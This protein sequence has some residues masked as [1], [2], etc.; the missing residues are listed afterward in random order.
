[1]NNILIRRGLVALAGAAMLASPAA[2]ARR[3]YVLDKDGT[4]ND[5]Q[6][7]TATWRTPWVL[8][9]IDQVRNLLQIGERKLPETV[10]VSYREYRRLAPRLGRGPGQVGPPGTVTLDYDPVDPNRELTFEPGRYAVDPDTTFRHYREPTGRGRSSLV[11]DLKAAILRTKLMHEAGEPGDWRG[12]AFP[13]LRQ[14]L[15]F[16]PSSNEL[17]LV[18]ARNHSPGEWRRFFGVLKEEGLVNF[19]P[20]ALRVYSMTDEESLQFGRDGMGPKKSAVMDAVA[21]DLLSDQDLHEELS[22]DAYEAARGE[23]RMGHTLIFGE[24]EPRYVD[25]LRRQMQASSSDL[26]LTHRI[27]FVLFNA[28]FDEEVAEAFFPWRYTVIH[29]GVGRAA[30]PA[31]IALW[32]GADGCQPLL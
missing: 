1:M 18:T 2:V 16:A 29:K 12:P 8:R 24:E 32:T 20:K 19:V 5:D 27:K 3:V 6:S 28:G 9:R 22:P 14:A 7:P 30:T 11:R 21:F 17:I 13:L 31:E 4:I 26:Y 25:S 23:T 15:R 10:E